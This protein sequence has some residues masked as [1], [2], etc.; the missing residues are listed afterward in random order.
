MIAEAM[1]W[2]RDVN[3][4]REKGIAVHEYLVPGNL[5]LL[6]EEHTVGLVV[7]VAQWRVELGRAR[8]GQGL[9]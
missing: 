7:S 4:S 3:A 8:D 6:T 9:T 1:A 2:R 5:H